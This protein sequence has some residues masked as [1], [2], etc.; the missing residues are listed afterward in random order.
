MVTYS[1]RD[2]ET[3]IKDLNGVMLRSSGLPG[4]AY[5]AFVER[6][7]KFEIWRWNRGSHECIARIRWAQIASVEVGTVRHG[8]TIDRAI[9]LSVL[10]KGRMVRLPISPQNQQLLRMTPAKDD[11][12][13]RA[14]H[15]LRLM[16]QSGTEMGQRHSP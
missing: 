4:S 6:G 1:S 7:P 15:H 16:Q 13:R 9:M 14:L 5:L 12:F 10:K 3:A 11:D 8:T 2:L